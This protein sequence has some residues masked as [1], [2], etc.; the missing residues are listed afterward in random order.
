M[1]QGMFHAQVNI[2]T[3]T[4]ISLVDAVQSVNTFVSSRVA[5]E[6][7]VTLA[8]LRYTHSETGEAQVELV[9]GGHVS[10]LI[11]RADGRIETIT[12]GDMPVGLFDFAHF[13]VIQLTL[14]VGDR[15]ILLSDGISEAENVDG[16]QFGLPQVERHLMQSDPVAALFLA[17]DQFCE[18][19]G[20]QDDQTVLSIHRTA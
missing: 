7:Y 13:H 2:Q 20:P 11:V 5:N 4:A 1:V 17:L 15:I 18:G 16:V 12:D 14:A 6:K 9:N 8:V 19:T 10:P 3:T